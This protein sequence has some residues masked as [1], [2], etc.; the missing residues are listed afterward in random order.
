MSKERQSSSEKR[1]M[2]SNAWFT[3]QVVKAIHEAFNANSA[4]DD[5][6]DAIASGEEVFTEKGKKKDACSG[7]E[8][9][10]ATECVNSVTNKEQ[11]KEDIEPGGTS[12]VMGDAFV[13]VGELHHEGQ[14]ASLG[15]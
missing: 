13:S 5:S 8:V 7:V 2:R 11:C 15:A 6:D 4:Y 9:N 3:E 10:D 12:L 14:L 1:K